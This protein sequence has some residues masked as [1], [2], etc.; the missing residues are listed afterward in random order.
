MTSVLL[1]IRWYAGSDDMTLEGNVSFLPLIRFEPVQAGT[2][3]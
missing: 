1:A 3:L 2:P